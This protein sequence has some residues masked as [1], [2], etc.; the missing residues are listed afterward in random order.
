MNDEDI[1]LDHGYP[2]RLIAPGVT[3]ARNVKWLSR[4][5]VSDEESHCHWQRK[6][7]KSFSPNIDWHNVDFES[8]PSI[9][10]TPIQSAFCEPKDGQTVSVNRD[11]QTI[12]LKG[13]AYCGGGRKVIRVDVS[14]DEGLNWFTAELEQEDSPLNRTYSWSLFKV[15]NLKIRI[16]IC[17][18]LLSV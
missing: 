3:G 4:I 12:E 6:D 18:V 11:K 15:N 17:K 7:Y 14:P 10:E 2:L 13:Y 16:S 8:A 1:P 9:Q 5:V